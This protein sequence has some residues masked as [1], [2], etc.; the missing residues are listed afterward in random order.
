MVGRKISITSIVAL[1]L[2][3]PSMAKSELTPEEIESLPPYIP[4][5][6]PP[7]QSRLGGEDL[8]FRMLA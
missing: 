3:P 6:E 2:L 7:S 1:L 5:K 8:L 4:E